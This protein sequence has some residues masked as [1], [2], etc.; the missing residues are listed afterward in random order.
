MTIVGVILAGGEGRRLGG[1]RKAD[2]RLG[3][4]ALIDWVSGALEAQCSA[5]VISSGPKAFS[6]VPGRVCL[7]DAENGIAGPT[8]GLLAGALWVRANA[9]DSLMLSVSVDTPFWPDDFARRAAD[10]LTGGH[11]CVVSA[12]GERDYPTNALWRPGPLISH[13]ETIA[14]AP[15]GPSIR[16]VQAALGVRRLDYAQTHA[17][18]PFAGVNT[19][20]DLLALS[21]RLGQPER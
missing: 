8:A 3:N 17:Q 20:G 4:R 10:L 21:R 9:R 12:F 11:H 18:N 2:L 5:I 16:S 15:R 7:A 14:P 19:C 6:A 1:V 13:L